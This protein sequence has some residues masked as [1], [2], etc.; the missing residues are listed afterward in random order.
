LLLIAAALWLLGTALEIAGGD[1]QT[2]DYWAKLQYLGIW[3]VPAGWLLYAIR[4]AGRYKEVTNLR[5]I[6]L[7]IIP[8]LT[9]IFA[10]TNDIFGLMWLAA[11]V[12]P[13]SP[14]L[15]K[16]LGI[17]Y[18]VFITHTYLSLGLGL[19]LIANMMIRMGRLY[20]WQ[21]IAFVVTVMLPWLANAL[22]DQLGLISTLKI[23]LTPFVLGITLPA[24]AWGLYRIRSQDILPVVRNIILENMQDVVVCMDSRGC[25]ADLNLAAVKLIGKPLPA[26]LGLTLAQGWPQLAAKL[27]SAQALSVGNEEIELH[28]GELQRT[29]DV[30]KSHIPGVRD[31]ILGSVI[32]LRDVT[33]RER[34]EK[35]LAEKAVELSRANTLITSLSRMAVRM[36]IMLE[37]DKALE[38][39]GTELASLGMGCLFW[40]LDQE[41]SSLSLRYISLDGMDRKRAEQLIGMNFSDIHLARQVWREIEHLKNIIEK[42]QPNYNSNSIS[43]LQALLPD[44]ARTTIEDLIEIVGSPQNVI[45]A[46]LPL[47][48]K[49]NNL[50]ILTVWG[51][52]LRES[53]LTT[54][55]IFANQLAGMLARSYL[56]TAERQSSQE[57]KRAD[58]FATAL[59]HVSRDVVATVELDQIL[60]T[61]GA[62]MRSMNISVFIAL[63]DI[64]TGRL[65]PRYLSIRSSNIAQVEHFFGISFRS[66]QIP[67]HARPFSQVLQ[68]GQAVYVSN[69]YELIQSIILP[70]SGFATKR[71][72]GIL[73]VHPATSSIN[74]PLQVREDIIGMMSV[75]GPDLQQSDVNRF[76]VFAGQIAGT[77]E[78][79]QMLEELNSHAKEIQ[80]SL[81]EKEILLREIHHRVKNNLQVVCSMLRLQSHQADD[82]RVADNLRDSEQR[83][84]SMALI[85]EK[86]YQSENF[87]HISFDSYLPSLVDDLSHIYSIDRDRIAIHTEVKDVSFDID[88]AIPFGLIANELVTNALKHAFPP[89]RDGE[90]RIQLTSANDGGKTLVVADNGIGLPADFD[91]KSANSL[92]LQLVDSLLDQLRGTIH[93]A[94]TQGT[95]IKVKI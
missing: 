3:Y 79:S 76:I 68:K 75:W 38:T 63:K 54:L 71:I 1:L 61:L 39:L 4:F 57:L 67:T 95:E 35:A 52:D 69:T 25:I 82:P 89:G 37:P 81:D 6:L 21:A 42:N 87:S 43:T 28:I 66:Y 94:C 12:D 53:D 23:E 72:L 26:V 64:E 55:S 78:K 7:M 88:T 85:H 22:V 60:D 45:S 86:L 30:S 8:F 36:E 47:R 40:R 73:D 31:Q 17:W 91:F 84:Q 5:L 83:V 77:L 14:F 20:R 70:M 50:G 92:G 74:L 19:A 56:Y 11:R 33:G 62:Q 24:M 93:I 90:I 2:K 27:G 51:T 15:Q 48:D 10:L 16:S 13:G 41:D 80:S 29:F 18:F 59:S 46:H 58:A 65:L 34:I 9:L 49:R 32:V 44:L